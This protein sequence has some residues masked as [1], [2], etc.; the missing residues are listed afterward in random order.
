[1]STREADKQ[2]SLPLPTV[3]ADGETFW[4][5]AKEERLCLQRCISC[6]TYR[7]PPG[8]LCRHCGSPDSE[9]VEVS[10][11]GIIYSFSIVRRGPTPEFSSITPYILALVQLEEGPRMMAHILED[12]QDRV[13]IGDRVSVVFEER[14]DGVKIPQFRRAT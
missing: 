8:Y 7:Y 5:S 12:A 9:W 3:N 11:R 2:N 14:R 13:S 1:M 4:A 6:H 10:G